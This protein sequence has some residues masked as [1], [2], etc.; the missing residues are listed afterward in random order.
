MTPT[1]GRGAVKPP[2]AA[3]TGMRTG[4]R[5][6]RGMGR[7]TRPPRPSRTH[8]P[9]PRCS[10]PRPLS[11]WGRPRWGGAGRG[12]RPGRS[13]RE[14]ELLVSRTAS[15][16]T[17]RFP[18]LGDA[19]LRQ[20]G[21]PRRCPSRGSM[22]RNEAWLVHLGLSSQRCPIPGTRAAFPKVI[23]SQVSGLG[24]QH[25]MAIPEDAPSQV[26]GLHPQNVPYPR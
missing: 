14:P 20:E 26:L 9:A 12:A 6:G 15:L 16:R 24:F 3:G 18:R 4:M 13:G 7:G 17:Q 1:G 11:A 21:G 10:A 8:R 23:S 25:Q 5:K 19:R 2:S 22:I